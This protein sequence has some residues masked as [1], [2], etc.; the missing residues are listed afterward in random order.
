[1]GIGL[2][3]PLGGLRADSFPVGTLFSLN[4][5]GT[6]WQW[7]KVHQ[8]LPS[9][10]YDGS[11]DGCWVMLKDIYENRQW[12]S[13]DI[14][15][16]SNSAICAYLDEVFYKLFDSTLQSQMKQVKIPYVAGKGGSTVSLGSNGLPVTVF[17]L[18]GNE[19]GANSGGKFPTD[20]AKLSY[21]E[22]GSSTTAINK[23]IGYLKGT[24]SY[25]WL[26]SPNT[27]NTSSAWRIDASG[28]FDSN[29]TIANTGVRPAVILQN[30]MLFSL[31][32][33]SDGSYSPLEVV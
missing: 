18:G 6:P 7:I 30:N 21:F 5:G 2:A 32:P 31:T 13:P 23:R 14:N 29:S 10:M 20:G 24:A 8:G 1:M 22:L 12:H 4:L 3:T 16:Y 25:W 9:S 26:R 28:T 11:C 33:N 17:L 19:V 27:S 15:D